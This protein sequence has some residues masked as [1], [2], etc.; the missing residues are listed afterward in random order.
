MVQRKVSLEELL[1]T[2]ADEYGPGVRIKYKD[3]EGDLVTISTGL[4]TRIYIHTLDI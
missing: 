3:A 4:P 2:V 1:A